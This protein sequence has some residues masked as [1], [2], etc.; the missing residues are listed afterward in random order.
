MTTIIGS[1]PVKD[2]LVFNIDAAS[3]SS[4]RGRKNNILTWD[5]WENDTSG[6]VPSYNGYPSYVLNGSESENSRISTANPWGYQ[7]RLVL[8]VQLLLGDMLF[9]EHILFLRHL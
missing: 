4:L 3:V 7:L 2:N 5:N 1:R 8:A 9:L 6:T